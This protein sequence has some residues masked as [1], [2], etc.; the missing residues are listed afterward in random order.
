MR[1]LFQVL[2]FAPPRLPRIT[3]DTLFNS[4]SYALGKK[5]GIPHEVIDIYGPL[6][7]HAKV[8]SNGGFSAEE[9]AAAVKSE[10]CSLDP[11]S[12]KI[13]LNLDYFLDGKVEGVFFGMGWIGHP[14]F[15]K[16]LEHGKPLDNQ[17]DFTTLYG[18]YYVSEDEQRQGYVDYPA[19]QY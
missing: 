4:S 5:R 2:L 12:Q 16:R 6:I 9:A 14:D 19:A 13:L 18:K 15:A 10:L 1:S 8:F 7:K 17:L 3:S 11:K